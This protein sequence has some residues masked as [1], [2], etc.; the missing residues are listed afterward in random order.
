MPILGRQL[1]DNLADLGP[2]EGVVASDLKPMAPAMGLDQPAQPMIT[3][4]NA[5]A[6]HPGARYPGIKGANQHGMTKLGLGRKTNRGRHGSL[7]TA[8]PIFGP[9]LRQVQRPIDQAVTMTA[10]IAEK[11][12]DLTIL[13]PSGRLE[14]WR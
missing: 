11:H 3:A 1:T 10:G 13:D 8:H 2:F 6:T 7:L 9:A 14:Y 12:P 4:I 5:I